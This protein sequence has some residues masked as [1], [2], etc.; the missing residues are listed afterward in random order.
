MTKEERGILREKASTIIKEL[1]EA[2]LLTPIQCKV[3]EY[4]E[5]V[6]DWSM[7]WNDEEIKEAIAIV[8]MKLIEG[9][10]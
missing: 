4:G 6:I 5:K 7:F 3:D 9:E 8:Y 1:F 2:D 10:V